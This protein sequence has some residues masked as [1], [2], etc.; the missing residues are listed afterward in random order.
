MDDRAKFPIR[1][2]KRELVELENRVAKLRELVNPLSDAQD[3][4][5]TF[6]LDRG[7]KANVVKL[8][9]E[10]L[11]HAGS[12]VS[13]AVNR[14][15][16]PGPVVLG[17]AI[18]TVTI[19]YDERAKPKKSKNVGVWAREYF[20]YKNVEYPVFLFQHIDV[21]EFT[22]RTSNALACGHIEYIGELVQCT[23]PALL[24]N[25]KGMGRKQLNEI[26]DKLK[27]QGLELGIKLPEFR[28]AMNA[29]VMKEG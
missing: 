7:I 16:G 5:P 2:L 17:P 28:A 29:Y 6:K 14:T 1:N 24:T 12:T 9:K 3:Y 21:L 4:A 26:K 19:T 11:D 13:V 20:T 27:E 8:V 25:F 15:V 22:V 23:E 10:A 18:M